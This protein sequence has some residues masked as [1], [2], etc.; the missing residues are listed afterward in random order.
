MQPLKGIRVIDL[1]KVLAGPI[2]TQALAALGA[3]VIKIENTDGGDETRRWAP[4]AGDTGAA[5]LSVNA[6]KRSLGLNLRLAAARDIVAKLVAKSDVVVQSF[7]PGVAEK[8]GVD[9]ASLSVANDKLIYCSISGFGQ[10][11]PLS[12]LPGYDAILQAFTGVMALNGEEDGP[13][14]RLPMS[15]VDQATAQFATQGILAALLEFRQSGKGSI[16]EVSLLETAV[17]MLAPTLQ[18]YWASGELPKRYGSGHPSISPYQVFETKDQPVLIAIANEK[19][20]RLFCQIAELEAIE[21]DPRFRTN[22]DRVKNGA[23][24]EA[25]VSEAMRRR[26]AAEWFD[27]F[28]RAGIPAAPLNTIARLLEHEQFGF[29]NIVNAFE[30]PA[31]G[32]ILTVAEPILLNGRRPKPDRAPPALGEHTRSIL[33]TELNFSVEKIEQLTADKV[34]S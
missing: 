14:V 7:A 24:T 26:T 9:Y 15:P 11:G 8:L 18:A 28:M 6:G 33:A 20:W 22:P 17:K 10:K 3:D 21:D 5:F 16:V 19:F 23:E 1:S 25:I 31:L 29:L 4:L 34:V 32:K 2:C 27:L 12:G 30:T 13:A